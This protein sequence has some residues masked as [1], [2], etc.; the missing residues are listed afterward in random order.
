MDKVGTFVR[1]RKK[2]RKYWE[3][4]FKILSFPIH[5]LILSSQYSWKE[6]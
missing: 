3:I 2:D 5:P 1:S 6:L 4:L